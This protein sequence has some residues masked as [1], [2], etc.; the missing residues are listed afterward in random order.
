MLERLLAKQADLKTLLK[1]ANQILD[2][3]PE[4][5][6]LGWQELEVRI[7]LLEAMLILVEAELARARA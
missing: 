7:H 2:R 3:A 4:L 6:E 5:R 1:E